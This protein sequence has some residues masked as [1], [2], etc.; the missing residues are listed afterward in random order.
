MG[1]S[2]PGSY[3][4][5]K[6]G[7]CQP[8]SCI[9]YIYIFYFFSKHGISLGREL[10]SQWL[11]LGVCNMLCND[12]IYITS[13]HIHSSEH[14]EYYKMTLT[15]TLMVMPL[16]YMVFDVVLKIHVYVWGLV[17]MSPHEITQVFPIKSSCIIFLPQTVISLMP[18]T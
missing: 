2:E 13:N 11:T 8:I 15:V 3:P 1:I 4:R 10:R 9:I 14:Q 17:H 5:I 6:H 18:L 7:I 12:I 16:P